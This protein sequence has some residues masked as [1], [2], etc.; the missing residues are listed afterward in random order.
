MKFTNLSDEPRWYAIHTRSQQEDRADAN[1]RTLKIETLA[2]RLKERRLDR[3]RGE[4]LY[5]NQ[6]IIP[7]I[8]F[9]TVRV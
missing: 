2:P 1:L 9:R 4:L 5:K 3:Y 7:Q 8:H 6:A